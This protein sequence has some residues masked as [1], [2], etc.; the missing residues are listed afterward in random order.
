MPKDTTTHPVWLPGAGHHAH[1][2]PRHVLR[3]MAPYKMQS[4]QWPAF[5]LP[6]GYTNVD[7][8]IIPIDGNDRLGDCGPCMAA[9]IDNVLTFRAGGAASV[10]SDLNAF[11]R[12]YEQ[13]SGGDRGTN[14][15]E[16]VG[17]IWGPPNGIA[18]ITPTG[19]V[20]QDHLDISLDAASVQGAIAHMGFACLAFSVPDRWINNFEPS[21]N[22]IWDAPAVPNPMHG[23]YVALVG[24]DEQGRYVLLTWGGSVR[25]T[26]AGMQCV[27]PE[28]FTGWTNRMFNPQT[29]LSFDGMTAAQKAQVYMLA[30]GTPPVK[31][32]PTPGPS[33]GPAPTPVPTPPPPTPVTTGWS[34]SFLTGA[35]MGM[36]HHTVVVKNG[37]ISGVQ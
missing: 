12:Q 29:G 1:F 3:K 9:H 36:G 37:L 19:A 21:G 6:I 11:E 35:G 31:P 30:G 22:T 7:N 14:E 34:G 28:L 5:N 4:G 25:L 32:D 24:V 2:T 33:P 26:Q 16:M 20:L 15:D 23:H 27:Q 17:P 10:M 8:S 18:G 13:V